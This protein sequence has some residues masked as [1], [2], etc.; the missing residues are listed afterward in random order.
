MTQLMFVQLSAMIQKVVMQF[1]QKVIEAV[2]DD[3][4][5]VLIL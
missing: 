2:C 3:G 1:D 4:F 5:G